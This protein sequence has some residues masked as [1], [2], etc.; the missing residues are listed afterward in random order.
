LRTAEALDIPVDE[1]WRDPWPQQAHSTSWFKLRKADLEWTRA[2]LVPWV[3]RQLRGES[4]GDGLAPKRPEL[5]PLDEVF[6]D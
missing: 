1:D 3:R 6:K 2:H 4:M 5:R